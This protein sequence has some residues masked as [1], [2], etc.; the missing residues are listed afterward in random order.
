MSDEQQSMEIDQLT[1]ICQQCGENK[2]VDL[3]PH[4]VGAEALMKYMKTKLTACAC[5]GLLCDI[6]ARFAKD[7]N[8][9]SMN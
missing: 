2:V 1:I 9:P 5:G 4:L 8:E 7:P 3:M 6:K